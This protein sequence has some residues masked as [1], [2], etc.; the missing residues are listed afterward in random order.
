MADTRLAQLA[1]NLRKY[2][3]YAAVFHAALSAGIGGWLFATGAD[4]WGGL[5]VRFTEERIAVGGWRTQQARCAATCATA[6]VRGDN[7]SLTDRDEQWEIVQGASNTSFVLF[8]FGVGL[9]LVLVELVTVAAH[10]AAWRTGDAEWAR[11]LQRNNNP[12]R[13]TEYALSA[14]VMTLAMGALTRVHDSYALLGFFMNNVATQLCGHL[15]E[16]LVPRPSDAVPR[17]LAGRVTGPNAPANRALKLGFLFF[18]ATWV[19]IVSRFS[20][21][22]N[23]VDRYSA[24]FVQILQGVTDVCARDAALADELNV[25]HSPDCANPVDGLFD[26][27]PVLQW[28][29]AAPAALF[30]SFAAVALWLRRQQTL[31]FRRAGDGRLPPGAYYR[32]EL[33]YVALSFTVKALLAGLVAT[34]LVQEDPEFKLGCA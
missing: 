16:V 26:I 20:Q 28:A 25:T 6:T 19:P 11:R 31:R 33:T 2:H 14:G 18:A 4:L 8:G 7:C 5:R 29:V 27:D 32:V 13:W 15:A 23:V 1:A 30:L 12:A 24:D 10:V 3:G 34:G 9:L 17:G 22:V 21:F